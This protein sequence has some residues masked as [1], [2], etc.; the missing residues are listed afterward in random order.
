M[1]VTIDEVQVEVTEAPT[2]PATA[3]TQTSGQRKMDLLTAL[4]RIRERQDRLK[5]D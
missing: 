4:E 3:P 2:Q 1:A 5:A